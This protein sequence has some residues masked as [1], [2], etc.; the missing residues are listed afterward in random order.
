[1]MGL[2]KACP[3]YIPGERVRN[4]S[5]IVV[6][7]VRWR[8]QVTIRLCDS[9]SGCVII[10][11]MILNRVIWRYGITDCVVKSHPK[12]LISFEYC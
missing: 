4:Q 6:T 5:V 10:S 12:Y 11:H 3:D 8:C 1:M 7:Y 9:G 2:T